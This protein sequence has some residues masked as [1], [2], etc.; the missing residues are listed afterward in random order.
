[1][2]P[3]RNPRFPAPASRSW[4]HDRLD[5]VAAYG[6]KPAIPFDEGINQ[7]DW[8]AIGDTLAVLDA[9]GH[10]GKMTVMELYAHL[11]GYLKSTERA[12]HGRTR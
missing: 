4:P 6:R 11:D 9:L 1:M 8:F 12:D 3:T 7:V 10:P 5:L 2:T